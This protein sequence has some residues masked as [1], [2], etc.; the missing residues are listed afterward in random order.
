MDN[1]ISIIVHIY[2]YRR[3][4]PPLYNFVRVV[5]VAFIVLS[6]LPPR[7]S[8]ISFTFVIFVQNMNELA[9]ILSV[10]CMQW[11]ANKIESEK[12]RESKGRVQSELIM[13]EMVLNT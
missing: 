4:H 2:H 11:K 13:I 1:E 9:Q 8:F 7:C 12:V 3:I 10:V 6:H 5:V